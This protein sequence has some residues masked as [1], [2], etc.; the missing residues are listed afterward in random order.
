MEKEQNLNK[1]A[2]KDYYDTLSDDAK[3]TVR[4]RILGELSLI[5][6]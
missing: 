3:E 6:I 5:H 2:F 1:M 4:N